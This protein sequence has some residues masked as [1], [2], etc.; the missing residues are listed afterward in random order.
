[1]GHGALTCLDFRFN[2]KLTAADGC[3][4]LCEAMKANALLTELNGFNVEH[5]THAELSETWGGIRSYELAHITN[6]IYF[7]A[8]NYDKIDATET[9]TSLDLSKCKLAGGF[10]FEVYNGVGE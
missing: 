4:V 8:H 7:S 6:R 10:P 1:M 5:S 9:L 2:E 3:D